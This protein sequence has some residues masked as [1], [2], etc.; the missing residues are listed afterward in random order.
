MSLAQ[1]LQRIIDSGNEEEAR[2]FIAQH[3]TEFP[4]ESRG[5]LAVELL[6]DAIDKTIAETESLESIKEDAAD[7]IDFLEKDAQA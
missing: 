4:E 7:M 5:E 1:D 2:T 6:A 3:W